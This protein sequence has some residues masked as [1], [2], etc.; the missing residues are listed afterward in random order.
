MKRSTHEGDVLVY[1]YGCPS[2]A[3]LD[4]AAERQLRLAHELRNAL[5]AI[6]RAH[7]EAVAAIWSEH[8]EVAVHEDVLAA[9][10]ANLEA[11][12]A[13]GK[14]ERM[15]TRTTVV[16]AATRQAIT[17]ARATRKEAK[18]A[19]KAAKDAAYDRLDSQEQD[20]VARSI[21]SRW[22]SPSGSNPIIT[23]AAR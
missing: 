4:E 8:P 22:S 17:A 16:S 20:S 21:D 11:A 15:R 7:A 14:D 13:A 9:A 18:A 23:G 19:H 3:K 5:V 2:W 12:I 1:K 10:E 6:H